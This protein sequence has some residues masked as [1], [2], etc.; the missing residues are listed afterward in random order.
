VSWTGSTSASPPDFVYDLELLEQRRLDGAKALAD[1]AT[2]L[3]NDNPLGLHVT[4][5]LV[6]GEEDDDGVRV[7]SKGLGIRADG[8]SGMVVYEDLVHRT[9]RGWRIARRAVI[10]RRRPL[11]G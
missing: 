7:R 8:S 4:S 6:I 9:D 3:G 5:S 2:A 1:A 11:Q 10:P